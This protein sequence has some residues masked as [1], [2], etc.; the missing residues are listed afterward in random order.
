MRNIIINNGVNFNGSVNISGNGKVY[1]NGRLVS[2]KNYSDK[3]KQTFEKVLSTKEEIP[4]REYLSI[5][6]VG[7]CSDIIVISGDEMS[8]EY[9]GCY[10]GDTEPTV[11]IKPCNMALHISTETFE[12]D[13]DYIDAKL[14]V[15]IPKTVELLNITS[16]S[17]NIKYN[18]EVDK[19]SANT[20]SGNIS[21]RS[22]SSKVTT[23]TMSGTTSVAL[24]AEKDT[25]INCSSMSGNIDVSPVNYGTLEL[26]AS[27]MS[28]NVNDRTHRNKFEKHRLS[29]IIKTMSGNINF[30]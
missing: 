4:E 2:D 25:I 23:E 20:T 30:M 29:G 15:T 17:G 24:S 3:D 12:E 8:I 22:V 21:G 27:T 28:G 9:K 11:R 10:I 6:I 16:T 26:R 14:V 13:C 19:I 5:S 18:V 7:L 1:V